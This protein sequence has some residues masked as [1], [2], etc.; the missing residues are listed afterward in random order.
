MLC[1]RANKQA[2]QV[3]RGI[4]FHD[5]RSS[6]PSPVRAVIHLFYFININCVK[7]DIFFI[8]VRTKTTMMYTSTPATRDECDIRINNAYRVIVVL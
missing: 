5:R 7:M 6:T 8:S 4:R 1:E 3:A 2:N